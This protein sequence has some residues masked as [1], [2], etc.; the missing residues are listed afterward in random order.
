MPAAAPG[1]SFD[2]DD[3]PMDILVEVAASDVGLVETPLVVGD[4][5]E[6]ATGTSAVLVVVADGLAKSEEEYG[7]DERE[8]L[9]LVP[10]ADCV[11]VL[12]DVDVWVMVMAHAWRVSPLPLGPDEG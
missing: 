6:S 10:V 11:D 9:S 12:L 8:L 3:D 1:E 2:G 4:D 5:E 7:K